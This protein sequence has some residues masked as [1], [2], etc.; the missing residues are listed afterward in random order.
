MCYIDVKGRTSVYHIQYKL[1]AAPGE[2]CNL[3]PGRRKAIEVSFRMRTH[4]PEADGV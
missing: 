2:L 1:V 3:L 4:E